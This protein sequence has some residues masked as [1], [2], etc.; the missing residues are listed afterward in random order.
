MCGRDPGVISNSV[1]VLFP[2]LPPHTPNGKF[3]TEI[4]QI[5][6]CSHGVIL[7]GIGKEWKGKVK[8][9]T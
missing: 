2:F 3:L 7:S 4:Q 5:H 6:M 8:M 9:A 1:S